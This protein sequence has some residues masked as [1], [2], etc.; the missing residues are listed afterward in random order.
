MISLKDVK[1]LDFDDYCGTIKTDY[2]VYVH[3]RIN[4]LST[5][6][7]ELYTNKLTCGVSMFS[8]MKSLLIAAFRAI[9]NCDPGE[10]EELD[11]SDDSATYRASLVNDADTESANLSIE[12]I[13][14]IYS[15]KDKVFEELAKLLSER[16]DMDEMSKIMSFVYCMRYSELTSKSTKS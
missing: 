11:P 2:G 6:T 10:I 12:L 13:H 1:L 7:S 3:F 9:F 14:K 16:N 8:G 5:P 4:S 15:S